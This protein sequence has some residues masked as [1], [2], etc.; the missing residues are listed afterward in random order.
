MGQASSMALLGHTQPAAGHV[1]I[2]QW[3]IPLGSSRLPETV[4]PLQVEPRFEACHGGGLDW[5]R[6]ACSWQTGNLG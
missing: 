2:H 6:Q 5:L 4:S 3:Y 1:H